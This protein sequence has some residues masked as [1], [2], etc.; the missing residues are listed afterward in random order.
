MLEQD[1]EIKHKFIKRDEHNP[2][3]VYVDHDEFKGELV[4]RKITYR[5]RLELNQLR[6]QYITDH[7][8][9]DDMEMAIRYAWVAFGFEENDKFIPAELCDDDLIEAL[10]METQRFLL[11]KPEPKESASVS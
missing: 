10:Y 1:F 11:V 9:M 5:Q 2:S 6:S 8:T 3:R 4:L 7:S